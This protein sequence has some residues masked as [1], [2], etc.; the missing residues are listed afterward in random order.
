M[1]RSEQIGDVAVVTLDRPERRNAVNH[2]AV[3][4]LRAAVAAATEQAA[5]ALVLAGAGG[6]FCAGADSEG[7][8]MFSGVFKIF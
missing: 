7:R 4:S 3:V 1:I 2:E 5:R 8:K 6:H